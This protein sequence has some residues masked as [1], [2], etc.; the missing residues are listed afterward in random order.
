MLV[1]TVIQL[2][3]PFSGKDRSHAKDD[4]ALHFVSQPELDKKMV[5]HG[6]V[7]VRLS[8]WRDAEV[9]AHAPVY[10]KIEEISLGARKLP[11][12]RSLPAF[13]AILNDVATAAL[14]TDESSA[15]I[16]KQAQRRRIAEK[17][18]F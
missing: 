18:L 9:R 16:L 7:G 8:T 4:V 15:E 11:R 1:N 5:R 13:A 17:I 10:G 12:S 6:T 3:P 2:M 14:T